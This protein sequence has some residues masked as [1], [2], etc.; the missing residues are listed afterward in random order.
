MK[1]KCANQRSYHSR[2]PNLVRI[3]DSTAHIA[4]NIFWCKKEERECWWTLPVAMNRLRFRA[5]LLRRYHHPSRRFE[6][7]R[8]GQKK[9]SVGPCMLPFSGSL[10]TLAPIIACGHNRLPWRSD[11][12]VRQA[13]R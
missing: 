10:L 3:S 12:H 7:Y 8:E 4:A 5:L 6:I 13:V 9:G 2:S 11:P 1:K